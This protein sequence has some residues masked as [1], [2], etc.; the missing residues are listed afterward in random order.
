MKSGKMPC[1]SV[2]FHTASK[3]T[4]DTLVRYACNYLHVRFVF[5]EPRLILEVREVI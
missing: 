1:T 3:G 4:A 5:V 2:D